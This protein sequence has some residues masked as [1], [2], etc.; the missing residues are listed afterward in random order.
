M[1][2]KLTKN[3]VSLNLRQYEFF[4]KKTNLKWHPDEL[5]QLGVPHINPWSGQTSEC[6][7]WNIILQGQYRN[8][9]MQQMPEKL[10]LL[11][12]LKGDHNI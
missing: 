5:T 3:Q 6:K 11:Y 12:L 8:L 10:Q 1:F 4:L 7:N 9:Q 2:V